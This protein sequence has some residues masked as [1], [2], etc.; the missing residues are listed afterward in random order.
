[1]ASNMAELAKNMEDL[2]KE[3]ATLYDQLGNLEAD[4]RKETSNFDETVEKI[5]FLNLLKFYFILFYD[6]FFFLI[7]SSPQ[8]LKRFDL[9]KV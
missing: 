6:E 5:E 8:M 1:M 4:L 9:L 2:D 3:S 7:D